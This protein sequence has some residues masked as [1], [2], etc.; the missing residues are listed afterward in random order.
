[1]QSTGESGRVVSALASLAV[2]WL[3]DGK[4]VAVDRVWTSRSP[5]SPEES[6]FFN[7]VFSPRSWAYAGRPGVR[8]EKLIDLALL[9]PLF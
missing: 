2:I 1:M 7:A 8:S 5:V 3:T 9:P 4:P 6:V